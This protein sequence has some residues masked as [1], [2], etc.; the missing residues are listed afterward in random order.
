MPRSLKTPMF[1]DQLA[2]V[3][4]V[5]AGH[6]FHVVKLGV[7]VRS[8]EHAVNVFPALNRACQSTHRAVLT[9]VTSSAHR[10]RTR[11]GAAAVG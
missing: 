1:S 10:C 3:P 9:S 6:P 8:Y 11:P 4:N 2:S 7:E 5:D